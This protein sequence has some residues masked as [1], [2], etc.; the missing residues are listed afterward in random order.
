M[1]S[2]ISPTQCDAIALLEMAFFQA[3][4]RCDRNVP[5]GPVPQRLACQGV[6]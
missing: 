6:L 4:Y 1:R 2:A 5:P 3:A